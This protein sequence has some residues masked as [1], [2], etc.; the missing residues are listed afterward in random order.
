M[1]RLTERAA[2]HLVI[3]LSNLMDAQEQME[4]REKL[5]QQFLKTNNTARV[6]YD[7]FMKNGGGTLGELKEWVTNYRPLPTLAEKKHMRLV[8]SE[9][10]PKRTRPTANCEINPAR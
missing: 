10:L 7:A 4:R 3:V 2:K 9:R 5:L 8:A 6:A 1:S